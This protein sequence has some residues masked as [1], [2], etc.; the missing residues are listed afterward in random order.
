ML[1]IRIEATGKSNIALDEGLA[2][3]KYKYRIPSTRAEGAESRI[4]P[5]T[6]IHCDGKTIKNN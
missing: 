4:Y 3:S 5:R 6:V 1:S 2:F